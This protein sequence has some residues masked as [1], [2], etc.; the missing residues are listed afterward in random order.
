MRKYVFLNKKNLAMGSIISIVFITFMII[1]YFKLSNDTY[2]LDSVDFHFWNYWTNVSKV[3]GCDLSVIDPYAGQGGLTFPLCYN[4]NPN[5]WF[6]MFFNSDLAKYISSKISI[7]IFSFVSFYI[8]YRSIGLNNNTIAICIIFNIFFTNSVLNIPYLKPNFYNFEH[9][10]SIQSLLPFASLLIAMF[11]LFIN[12]YKIIFS[13]LGFISIFFWGFLINPLYIVIYYFYP[14]IFCGVFFLLN[15][16]FKKFKYLLIAF[17]ILLFSGIPLVLFDFNM[18]ARSYFYEE[19][20][21]EVQTFDYLNIMPFSGSKP[22]ILFFLIS[23]MSIFLLLFRDIYYKLN[24]S[25]LFLHLISLFVGLFYTFGGIKWKLPSPS[26]FEQSIYSLFFIPIGLVLTRIHLVKYIP[27]RT[28]L[29]LKVII[30]SCFISLI[31][32]YNIFYNNQKD[33]IQ[34]KNNFS[35]NSL[36]VEKNSKF[37]GSIATVV[38]VPGSPVG[39]LLG[40]PNYNDPFNKSLIGGVPEWIRRNSS[41]D[42]SLSTFW[43]NKISTAE[44]NNHLVSPYKYFFFSRLLNRSFDY[45]SRNWLNITKLNIPVMKLIGIK[46][47]L[48]DYSLNERLIFQQS[49]SKSVLLN[50]YK[51]DRINNGDYYPT[52]IIKCNSASDMVKKM[53]LNGDFENNLYV[54]NDNEISSNLVRGLTIRYSIDDYDNVNLQAESK[55]TSVVVLPFEFRNSYR[56]TGSG[57]FKLHRANIFMT[58]VSFSGL[59]NINISSKFSFFDY[60]RVFKDYN[61]L[62]TYKF[63]QD[64]DKYPLDYQPYS[65]FN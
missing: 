44:D 24:L 20:Y 10:D 30:L 37:A 46:F 16:S 51:L 12:D 18:V 3:C 22:K 14:I 27:E 40:Y 55:G 61:E 48:T 41:N 34:N 39:K 49:I 21:S 31:F 5:N 32:I 7:L 29:R 63:E 23:L 26:Y 36:F 54:L 58:A 47:I 4:L 59:I 33:N 15:F 19:I 35:L 6:S 13:F 25:I 38:G 45:Q 28:E 56:I 64:S 52:R 8:L 50:V 11:F 57:R 1:S 62:K 43:K 53:R 42:Y 65:L 60:N 17:C 2:N 9:L